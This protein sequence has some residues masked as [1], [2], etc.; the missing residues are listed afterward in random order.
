MIEDEDRELDALMQSW[1]VPDCAPDFASRVVA[2]SLADR[3]V[4]VP[5]YRRRLL[6]PLML[7]ACLLSAGAFAGW[8]AH[9]S[10]IRANGPAQP[11]G[12]VESIL[13]AKKS[14]VSFQVMSGAAQA[15]PEPALVPPPK[16]PAQRQVPPSE[17]KTEL[18]PPPQN[19]TKVH[20]PR[21]ECGIS[22]IVCACSD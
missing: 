9:S 22:A 10:H 4:I 6:V 7:A 5:L 19:P 1:S 12:Q 2:R 20:L 21:C 15:E 14:R 18:P 3:G 11:S 13:A 17:T 8:E 16:P